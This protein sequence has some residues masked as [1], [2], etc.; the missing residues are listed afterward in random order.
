MAT[1]RR[2]LLPLALACAAL[3][4]LLAC[5]GKGDG[6]SD[7]P[8]PGQGT[9]VPAQGS[10]ATLDVAAWNVDWFGDTEHGPTDEGRQLQNVRD[11]IAGTDCDL[12]GLEEVVDASAFQTL[13]KGLPGYAGLLASDAAVTYGSAYYTGDEQKVALVY[14]T[15]LATLQSARLILVDHNSDFAGRPPLEACFQITQ[16]GSTHTVYVICFHAK[17]YSDAQSYQRRLNA[18]AALKQ[19][20]DT[21]RA[22]DKVFILGDYNDDLD[23]SITSGQPSPYQNFVADTANYLTPTKALSDAGIATM[24]THSGAV[25]HQIATSELA[26]AYVAG[27]AKAFRADQYLS[28]YA[29]STTD[30][31]PV[32]TRWTLP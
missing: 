9:A 3:V 22:N 19:Y 30:H 10:A 8:V 17:A 21:V 15:G 14:K 26:G 11:V 23:A 12:W 5:G 31:L 18:S 2:A 7:V 25:D 28:D 1:P 24:V 20:L 13:L 4:L 6:N 27:S 29:T 16:G 32:M